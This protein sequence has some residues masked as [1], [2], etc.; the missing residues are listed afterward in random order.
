MIERRLISLAAVF[1]IAFFGVSSGVTRFYL[2][3]TG[4][5]PISPAYSASWVDTASASR[6]I[7]VT[8]KTNSPMA[9]ATNLYT[10]TGRGL[11]RQFISSPLSKQTISG[12]VSGE[13]LSSSSKTTVSEVIIRVCS[14]DGTTIRGTL[15]STASSTNNFPAS[16]TSR[17]TP[18]VLTLTAVSAEAGDRLLIEIGFN[19]TGT[20]NNTVTQRF[21]DNGGTDI[22]YNETATD[23]TQNPW[24]QFSQTLTFAARR[25]A[26]LIN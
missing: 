15:L 19:K 25:R 2:T 17:Y 4:T 16:L 12:S 21:G 22:P 10:G 23:T 26:V 14:S 24:V 18:K 7:C 6:L 5:P 3:S 1:L 8:V 11:D 9:N 13:V 20:G